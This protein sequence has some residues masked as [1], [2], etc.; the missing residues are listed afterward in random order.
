M[1]SVMAGSL[2]FRKMRK[3]NLSKKKHKVRPKV[4]WR[5]TN[6]GKKAEVKGGDIEAS[7]KKIWR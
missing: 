6:P 4:G 1:V 2:N 7:I 5:T 3:S